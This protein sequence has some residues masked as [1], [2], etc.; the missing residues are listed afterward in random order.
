MTTW[1]FSSLNMN[2][3]SKFES[4]RSAEYEYS[5]QSIYGKRPCYIVESHDP[6]KKEIVMFLTSGL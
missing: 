6:S 1:H 3:E 2:R 5:F 4:R